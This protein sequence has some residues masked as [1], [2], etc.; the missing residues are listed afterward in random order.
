[1]VL[2]AKFIKNKVIRIAECISKHELYLYAARTAYF[3]I[4]SSMP[5]LMLVVMAVREIY[6]GAIGYIREFLYDAMPLIFDSL[7]PSAFDGFFSADIPTVSFA[8]AGMI[9]SASKGIKSLSAGLC[10][11]YGCTIGKNPAKRYLLSFV[12]TLLFI[13]FTVALL[14]LSFLGEGAFA[15]LDR[16]TEDV[17]IVSLVLKF[18]GLLSMIVTTFS[19]ALTYKI[20]AARDYTFGS[21]LPGGAFCGMGFYVYSFLFSLYVKYFSKHSI[22]YGSMGLVP[23]TMLW[24]YSLAVIFLLGAEVNLYI[25]KV[26]TGK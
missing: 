26:L 23:V 16:I 5:F 1:M 3:L 19:V 11:I 4:F 12:N 6:P 9:W 10:A 18:R 13:L 24:V 15:R 17:F 21:L 7:P 8:A 2:F 20:L 14:V 25:R 22:I